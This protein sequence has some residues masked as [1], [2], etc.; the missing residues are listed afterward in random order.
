MT[1]SSKKRA[2]GCIVTNDYLA[3]AL[4]AHSYLFLSNA[5]IPFT[6]FTIGINPSSPSP[7]CLRQR[8]INWV[9]VESIICPKEF[10]ELIA[11]YTAF[12]LC[13]AVRPYCHK[14]FHELTIVDQWAI[15]DSDIAVVGSL[16]SYFDD[17]AGNSCLLTPHMCKLDSF[18]PEMPDIDMI[19]L[20]AGLYNAGI[21]GFSKT[22]TTS[23]I[24]SWLCSRMALYCIDG[25]GRRVKC[26]PDPYENSSLF[27]DQAFISVMPLLFSGCKISDNPCFNLGHWNLWQ[28][29]LE[30]GG[31]LNGDKFYFNGAEVTAFHF[32]GLPLQEQDLELVSSHSS[33]Y[34][35][36][37]QLNWRQVAKEYRDH[38]LYYTKIVGCEDYAYKHMEPRPTLKTLFIRSLS[39]P[40]L[41]SSDVT[42]FSYLFVQC[43][44]LLARL[45]RGLLKL[46]KNLD[47]VTKG[48]WRQLRR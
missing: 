23:L 37:P 7:D 48:E 19:S 47:L 17:L 22:P 14:Y 11:R 1:T 32:S 28:G 31:N 9:P 33:A 18:S 45:C 3:H 41:K 36:N 30:R 42:D 38:L 16:D 40:D 6:V 10:R 2:V 34:I 8:F 46:F 39:S 25:E 12:E 20:K 26:I 13:C 21:I 35:D 43:T 24:I 27:V 5:G 15:I 4:C 44:L 29:K